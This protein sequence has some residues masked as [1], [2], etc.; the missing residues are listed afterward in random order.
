MTLEWKKFFSGVWLGISYVGMFIP[1]INCLSIFSLISS[2][3]TLKKCCVDLIALK[4]G[5]DEQD[6]KKYGLD[7]YIYEIDENNEKFDEKKINEKFEN[8]IFYIGPIQCILKARELFSQ[9]YHFF[10]ELNKKNVKDWNLFKI[11]KI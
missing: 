8:I 2:A 9:L 4:Y 10:E 6:I 5:F 7:E 1:L 11:E 3:L